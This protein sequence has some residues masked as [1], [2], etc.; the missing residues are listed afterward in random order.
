MKKHFLINALLLICSIFVLTSCDNSTETVHQHDFS[1]DWKYD[2][3]VHYHTCKSEE[4]NEVSDS[5]Q[6]QFGQ[7]SVLVQATCDAA[8]AQ[9]RNCSVCGYKEQENVPALGHSYSEWEVKTPATETE[10]E[11][12]HRICSLCGDEE[13]KIIENSKLVFYEVKFVDADGTVLEVLSVKEGNLPNFSK[14]SPTKAADLVYSY[15]FTGW[16][17]EVVVA[18]ADKTYTAVYVQNYINYSIVFKDDDGFEISKIENYHY[19][20]TVAIPKMSCKI[21]SDKFYSFTGWDNEVTT[22][23][24]DATYIAKY[25]VTDLTGNGSLVWSESVINDSIV[26]TDFYDGI[27]PAE[28]SVVEIA[29]KNALMVKYEEGF[30][31]LTGTVKSTPG[32]Q[33]TNSNKFELT[34]NS[35]VTFYVRAS[36]EWNCSDNKAGIYIFYDGQVCGVISANGKLWENATASGERDRDINKSTISVMNIFANGTVGDKEWVEV[37]ITFAGIENPDLS[38]LS[39]AYGTNEGSDFHG[40]LNIDTA[41]GQNN[42]WIYISDLN[43]V[44]HEKGSE[45]FYDEDGHWYK[46]TAK[47]CNEIIDYDTHKFGEWTVKTPA[48]E[49]SYEVQSRTCSVCGKEETKEIVETFEITFVN[50]DGTVLDIIEVD[51]GALPTFTSTMPTKVE[52]TD[53]I[54]LFKGWDSELVA[55]TEDKTYTAVYDEIAKTSNGQLVW[56]EVNVNY[57]LVASD[58]YAGLYPADLTVVEI[59]GRNA[60]QVKYEEGFF[61]LSGTVKTTP[62]I[63]FVNNN[64]F[65]LTENS[66]VTFYVRANDEWNCSDNKAGIFVFYDG[67]VCGTISTTGKLW[68]NA[69]ATGERDRYVNKKEVPV[70]NIFANGTISDKEWVEVKITFKGIDNPDLSKLSIA[71]G[72][73]EGSDFHGLLNIDTAKGQ[74]NSW[75]Y[76][77]DLSVVTHEKG[78]EIFYDEDGHWYKCTD[79]DCNEILDYDTHKFGEWTVK[80]PATDL[81]E[82]VQSRTCTVCGKEETKTI[83][84]ESF[85]VKFVDYDGTT[86]QTVT[87]NKGV[88]PTYTLTSPTK[89]AD[90]DYIYLFKGWDSELV[91]VTEDKTYTAVYDEIAKTSNGQLIWDENNVNYTIA[92]TDFYAGLHP[93]DLSVVEIDGRNAIQVKYEEGFFDLTGTVKTTPG[94]QFLNSNKFILTENSVVTFYVRAN[95]EWNCSDNKAGIFIFYDGQVCGTIST[96]GKL[97]SGATATGERDRDIKKATISV[98]NIFAN[99]TIGDKEWVE[100]KVTFDGIE[101]PDLSKLSIAYGTNEGSDFHGLLN[102]D[103]AKG[104]NNS[105]IYISDLSVVTEE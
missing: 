31:E 3:N 69:T 63:Q 14:E 85:E 95:D 35:V 25:S 34:E 64:K 60:L 66:V 103:T 99:G 29:G 22:V 83:V 43:V 24:A 72:T 93:T 2:S 62:G 58:F 79:E 61:D 88:L 75:I 18:T 20:D 67:Q 38:K 49:N 42:S 65:V 82:E 6:H 78:S 68:S 55:V 8:G 77:S 7:W 30:F 73:N 90:D 4:C 59:D 52:T 56:D 27:H 33:F 15:E 12:Q 48:T 101:N 84:T 74:Y 36:E 70:L 86:L 10:N 92:A 5:E 87:V 26:A 19:G 81:S 100:V 57:T 46:C 16:D 23:I 39:I 21:M 91:A 11:V 71:Y 105:W 104:Q 96:T 13:T 53:Y 1:S 80:T 102:I 98:T 97:W 28:L 32:I 37:K 47:D 94:I 40:L 17:S 50:Y 41:K 45:I 76:V 51:K 54:Y 44:T 9:E 89:E